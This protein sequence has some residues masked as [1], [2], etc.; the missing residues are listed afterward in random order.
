MQA[1]AERRVQAIGEEGDED[2]R[3]DAP[4][5]L[6]VDRAKGEIALE[7]FESFFH[8]DELQIVAPK[9]RRILLGQVGPKEISAFAPTRLA[10]FVTI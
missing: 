2:M 4:L 5:L 7:V 9:L 8:R 3:L 1:T 6:V 10:E